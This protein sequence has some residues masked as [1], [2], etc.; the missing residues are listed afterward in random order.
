MLL[1]L[2]QFNVPRYS[3]GVTLDFNL[4]SLLNDCKC[5]KPSR[6]A[7]SLTFGRI[8]HL[9]VNS[10]LFTVLV[11]PHMYTQYF[12]KEKFVVKTS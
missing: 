5:S 7:I 10:Y 2:D 6:K 3:D 12:L 4:I 11:Y 1:I 8:E 9:L